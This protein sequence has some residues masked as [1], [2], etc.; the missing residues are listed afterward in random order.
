M[1]ITKKWIC[2]A[3]AAAM[4][5]SCLAGCGSNTAG[6]SG[7]VQVI[8]VWSMDT[9]S[10]KFMESVVSEYNAREGKEKGIQ[11][12]YEVKGGD[13]YYTVLDVALQNNE[14]PEL[15]VC[16]SDRMIK[17]AEQGK[18]AAYDDLPGSKELIEKYK[19]FSRNKSNVYKGRT[20]SLPGGA[21]TV[22]GLVYNKDMFKEA[23]LVD[24]KGEAKPPETF[25]E[26]REYAKKLTNPEKR[27]YG[28]ALPLKWEGWFGSDI[29]GPMMSCV[30]HDGF[31]PVTGKYDY[32]AAVPI[33]ETFM[34]IKED[35]S[36]FPGAE[37][38][39]NDAALAQ[40]SAGNIGMKM[41]FSFDYAVFTQQ[42]PA[43]CDWGVA[44]Y[45]V[46]DKN[47]TYKQRMSV[48]GSYL[49]S[50]RAADAIGGDKIME[51]VKFLWEGIKADS[52]KE[53]ISI[54]ADWNAVKDIELSDNMRQWKGFAELV[55]ISTRAPMAPSTGSGASIKPQDLFLAEVWNGQKSAAQFAADLAEARN[56]LVDEYYEAHPE[57]S[58]DE[59]IDPQWDTKR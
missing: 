20:Y 36:Y 27:Q 3:A 7:D 14:E 13:S 38:L 54:P 58:L 31:D 5:L 49:I 51:A 22:Q 17:L 9:H 21:A 35:E 4:A 28:I 30:G 41:A 53:G 57:E 33:I 12:Q 50:K 59:L 39:D 32:T 18:I 10:Q 2:T 1:K 47:Q 40:F 16:G 37:G 52:F 42:F 55:E 23:G 48:S 29:T 15:F 26:L 34:G 45:P 25:E 44:P 6:N 24:E 46:V 8:R 43:T 56:A 11:I 19:E